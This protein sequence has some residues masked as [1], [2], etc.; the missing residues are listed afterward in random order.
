M[1]QELGFPTDVLVRWTWTDALFMP[2]LQATLNLAYRPEIPNRDETSGT[3]GAE[4]SAHEVQ[5]FHSL[6]FHVRTVWLF[7]TTL[8]CYDAS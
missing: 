2:Y 1:V 6:S 7:V 8:G 3:F 4:F 5:S